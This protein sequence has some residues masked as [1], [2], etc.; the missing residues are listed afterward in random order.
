[1]PNLSHCIECDKPTAIFE[2]GVPFCAKCAID[3][4]IPEPTT[5]DPYNKESSNDKRDNTKNIQD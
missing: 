5:A 3:N 4:I 2:N 1:M